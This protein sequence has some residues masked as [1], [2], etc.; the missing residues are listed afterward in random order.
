MSIAIVHACLRDGTGGSP[1]AV[2][3]E[4][5]QR[6]AERRAI[7]ARLGTSHAVFVSVPD[8]AGVSVRF[9]T[10]HGELPA[11][12]HGTVAALAFLAERADGR[13]EREFALHTPTGVITGTTERVDGRLVAT[14]APGPVELR[15]P[16][17]GEI[18]GVLSAVGVGAAVGA[19]VATLGRP[20]LLVPVPT[21]AASS[22]SLSTA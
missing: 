14:F 13:E 12:G 19:C 1:T 4:A 5:G 11:C 18:D 20:R 21:A 2:L 10:A 6:D 8:R 3:H 15:E 22:R 9:F 17:A 16:A 7:P